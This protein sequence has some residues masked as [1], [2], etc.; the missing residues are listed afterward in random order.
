MQQPPPPQPPSPPPYPLVIFDLE[1]NGCRGGAA[2]PSPNHCIL[3]ISAVRDDLRVAEFDQLVRPRNGVAIPAD[4]TAIHRIDAERLRAGDA[5]SFERAW[6]DFLAWLPPGPAPCVLIAHNLFGFDAVVLRSHLHRAFGSTA[7]P[8]H[9]LLADTLP[10]FR[11]ALPGLPQWDTTAVSPYSLGSLMHYYTGQ[12]IPGQHDALADV[13]ALRTIVVDHLGGDVV[14]AAAVR[15]DDEAAMA[16]GPPDD[17][18]LLRL[19][20]VGAIRADR[21]YVA[22]RQADPALAPEDARTVGALRAFAARVPRAAVEAF[23]RRQ[24][25]IFD[26]GAVACVLAQL[27]RCHVDTLARAGFPYCAGEFRYKRTQLRESEVAGLVAAG[28]RTRTQL[29]EHFLYR[30]GGDVARFRRWLAGVGGFA[31]ARVTACA[32]ALQY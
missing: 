28:V 17:A 3:Q 10:L 25:G 22:L 1:T 7:L 15:A 11:A 9:V 24:V 13:R 8:D 6:A 31:A 16:A 19:R 14:R 4:S 27:Y 26:D 5:V 29:R 32:R 23:L 21:C 18:P 30:C 20:Q 12:L 2:L